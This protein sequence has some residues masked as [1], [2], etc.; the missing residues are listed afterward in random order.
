[1]G[2]YHED[3]EREDREKIHAIALCFLT[4]MAVEEARPEDTKDTQGLS[5]RAES[6]SGLRL[7]PELTEEEV[8]RLPGDVKELISAF[9]GPV[10][11]YRV[12]VK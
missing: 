4:K 12:K 10:R 11:C 9:S 1:M 2:K 3:R 6:F 8:A 5:G 7:G